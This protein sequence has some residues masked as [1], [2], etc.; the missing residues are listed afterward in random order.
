MVLTMSKRKPTTKR[1]SMSLVA[2]A[3]ARAGD[4]E[5]EVFA[6]IFA[7]IEKGI[8]ARE[9]CEAEGINE[10]TFRSRV[11]ASPILTQQRARARRNLCAKLIDDLDSDRPN[12]AMFRLE[13]LFRQEY[14]KPADNHILVNQSVTNSGNSTVPTEEERA[15][16]LRDLFQRELAAPADGPVVIVQEGKH[17]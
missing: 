1:D 13:R 8:S 10:A 4:A 16:V 17:D 14:G 15:K 9:A 6:R 5:S 11:L 12:A 2:S 3:S 7:D